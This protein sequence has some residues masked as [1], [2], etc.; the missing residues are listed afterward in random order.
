[1]PNVVSYIKVVDRTK[2]RKKKKGI[3]VLKTN[4]NKTDLVFV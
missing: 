3:F 2:K 4:G 1:M